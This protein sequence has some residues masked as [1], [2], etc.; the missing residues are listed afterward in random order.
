KKNK[1]S[2]ILIGFNS[3]YDVIYLGDIVD[4]K[5]RLDAGSRFIQAKTVNGTKIYDVS[6]HVIGTLEEWIKKLNMPVTKRAGYL[7]SEQGKKEQ[8]LDDAKATYILA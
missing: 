6:N 5:T 7:D 3:A 4:S 2:F 1:R 8:V